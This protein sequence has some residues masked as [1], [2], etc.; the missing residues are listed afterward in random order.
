MFALI[1]VDDGTGGGS[2]SASDSDSDDSDSDDDGDDGGSGGG[3][4][5]ATLRVNFLLDDTCG[6]G[7]R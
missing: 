3:F 2:S 4:L 5:V 7:G 6:G 1:L